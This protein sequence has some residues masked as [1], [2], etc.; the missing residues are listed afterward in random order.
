LEDYA[1]KNPKSRRLFEFLKDAYA[2]DDEVL[3]APLD[4]CGWRSLVQIAEGTGSAANTLYGKRP[5]QVGPDLQ[6]LITGGLVEMRYF[7]GERGRG[8]EVMRFR[9]SE[10]R[11][12]V[13]RGKRSLTADQESVEAPK[14]Q[15]HEPSNPDNQIGEQGRRHL[16]TIMFTD[17]VGYT[18]L[19]QKDESVSI[20]LIQESNNLLRPI[21]QRHGGAIVKTIGDGFL[22][23]FP[24]AL[25]GVRCGYD[26]QRAVRE[27]NIVLP[28]EKRFSLRIGIH[29]GDVVESAGDIFGDAVNV[30]SRVEPLA[31][32]GG[33]C[34]TRQVYDQVRNKIDLT[35][36]SLGEKSLKNVD[37]PLEVYKVDL[38]WDERALESK[39][40]IDSN[41]IA[42]LPYANMSPDP[43][44]VYF[45]DGMTEEIISTISKIPTLT[46]ISRTSSMKYRNSDKSTT[47]IGKELNVGKILEGSVRKS[48]SKLRIT[49]QLID[50][51]NDVHLWSSS[52]DKELEDVFAIQSE[53]AQRVAA[54]LE[55][56]L[57]SKEKKEIQDA[58]PTKSNEAHTLFL[59][60]RYYFNERRKEGIDKAVKYFEK[61]IEL[62]TRFALAYSAL[63]D[64]YIVYADSAWLAPREAFRRVK[65]YSSEA[66]R[67]DPGLAEPHASIGAALFDYDYKWHEGE[68]ELKRAIELNPS[69]ATAYH[70]LSLSLRSEG[71]LA[72]S[73][74]N[75]L[76]AHELDPLSRPIGLNVGE[77]LLATGKTTE[78][79]RQFEKVIR[80]NQ[81]Y[82]FAYIWLGWGYYMASRTSEAIQ[83]V[84]KSVLISHEDPLNK[85]HLACLLGF[86]GN[87]GEASKIV[88]ELIALSN[89]M[90]V[91]SG[92]IAYALFGAGR[93][94]EGFDYLEKAYQERSYVIPYLN[95]WPWFRGMKKDPRFVAFMKKIGLEAQETVYKIE[96]PLEKSGSD[97]TKPG[98]HLDIHR[99][100]VLPFAN[101]SPD[102]NDEYFA[103]GLTEEL[104]STM[105]RLDQVEVISRTSAMQYKKNPK[106]STEVSRELNVGTIIE[107]SVS[108]TGNRLRITAEMID[109][110]KD[111]RLWAETYDRDLEDVFTVQS[112]VAERVASSLRAR[113]HAPE[114]GELTSNIEAYTMYLRA[115]QLLHESVES[116]CREAIALFEVAISKDPTF[117]RAY[118][119][120]AQA[121]MM[122]GSW[123]NWADFTFST[124]EAEVAARKALELGPDSAEAH[125]VM[126]SVHVAM[127]RFE[128]SQL[129]LE[130]AIR[131][132]PNLSW[133][134][135][136]LATEY[137]PFGRFLEAV[138]YIQK[139]CYLD[140][141]NPSPVRILTN[142][143]RA[144]GKVNEALDVV[145]RFKERDR[146]NPVVYLQTALCYLQTRNFSRA[147]EIL[148]EGLKF[149]PDDY[150]LRVARGMMYALE[151]RRGEAMDELR[152]LM[153]DENESNRRDAQVW[154]R[155]SMGDL[156][157][158][159]EA[160]MKEAEFHSWWFLIKFDPFFENLWKDPRFTEFCEKVGL[161]P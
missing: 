46:V 89:T 148:K 65:E 98:D 31:E 45:A 24:D 28:A 23:Q 111:R 2:K 59:K 124:N 114:H 58:R 121:W 51:V 107:G 108:K 136:V 39:G 161:P 128:E 55:I 146:T 103:D 80:E 109:A 85:A 74:T 106:S 36:T 88:Q 134:N 139:A 100:A 11:S 63:A 123:W 70:W 3:R 49:T 29:L 115:T 94:D 50:S 95:W 92:Q 71:R 14:V 143:L 83:A 62:D 18:A 157:E 110:T 156:D 152:D 75:I 6:D 72:E 93:T 64:C 84:R 52:Y 125:A 15:V 104:I 37:L 4:R 33:V 61:A 54:A 99:I 112:Q 91:D 16:A 42:V 131:I 140:P 26:I 144:K 78:A 34:L 25:N 67:L 73:Y 153:A 7:E 8:G 90:Y 105:S 141:L 97:S 132:N 133:A 122:M 43:N 32:G 147:G 142:I 20:T 154:I 119:G 48:G 151:G 81:D 101:I 21:F 35:F 155:T 53:I 1:F 127:D 82:A 138:N 22:I 40:K 19:G 68:I 27:F 44:D 5:G 87:Q 102:P 96:L 17:M 30:A 113:V 149:N 47:E 130:K 150:W 86:S 12:M 76:R 13:Q 158:A 56:K 159:F 79:V 116:S 10:P 57:F 66:I 60:G 135:E 41:R 69:Y 137:A 77:V 9:I 118:S 126:G 145:R 117:S 160:L 129:E 120:L 38:P